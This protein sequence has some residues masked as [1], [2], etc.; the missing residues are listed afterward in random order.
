MLTIECC[1]D[2]DNDIEADE[3]QGTDTTTAKLQ[4]M[5]GVHS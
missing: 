4:A 2:Y 1:D 5:M 3:E